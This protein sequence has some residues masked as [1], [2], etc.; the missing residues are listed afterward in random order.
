MKWQNFDQW[1]QRR[2]RNLSADINSTSTHIVETIQTSTVPEG[3]ELQTRSMFVQSGKTST[4]NYQEKP[5]SSKV[6]LR[7]NNAKARRITWFNPPY[8]MNVASSS[9]RNSLP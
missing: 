5:D 6:H 7:S 9:E 1:K 8:S 4:I 3:Y 2:R